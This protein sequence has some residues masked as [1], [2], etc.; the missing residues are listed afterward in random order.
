[1]FLIVAA[2]T[3]PASIAGIAAVTFGAGG[4]H[5]VDRM[6]GTTASAPVIN[7]RSA[8]IAR[9]AGVWPGVFRRPP[10]DC[11]MAGGALL[12]RKQ[13]RVKSRTAVTACA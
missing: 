9:D 5:Q 4:A 1:M 2:P 13:P 3:A 10:R 6:A 11:C 7:S 8:L 12:S